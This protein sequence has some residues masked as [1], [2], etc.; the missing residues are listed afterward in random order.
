[1]DFNPEAYLDAPIEK[2]LERRL[3][4]S[5]TDYTGVI[6]DAK[7]VPWQSKDKIDEL[8]GQFMSGI[9]AELKVS[10]EVPE[11]ERTRCNLTGTNFV[12]T[13]GMMLDLTPTK[14]IDDSPGRNSRLRMY[15]EAT[16]QNKPGESFSIR[17]LIGKA[18]RIKLGHRV[19]PSGEP[20]E[21]VKLVAKL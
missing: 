15:R 9:R 1:M 18:V 16:D 14:A 17:K 7:I 19:L 11:A 20:T 3:P 4:L 10:I 5:P 12:L 13:D 8:T 21:E 2:P 6:Q